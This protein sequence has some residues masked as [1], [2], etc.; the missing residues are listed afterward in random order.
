LPPEDENGDEDPLTF[1]R[2]RTLIST[3]TIRATFG[4]N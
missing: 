1:R 4:K 2:K 3:A